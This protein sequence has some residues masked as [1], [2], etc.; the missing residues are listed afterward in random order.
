MIFQIVILLHGV[1]NTHLRI[2]VVD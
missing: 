1:I 2:K